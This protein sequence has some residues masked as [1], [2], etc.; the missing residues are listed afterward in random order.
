MENNKICNL[1]F[2]KF[3]RKWNLARHLDDVH[4]IHYDLEK[5][6]MKQ[7]IDVPDNITNIRE[8]KHKIFDED[9]KR[10][11]LQ[12]NQNYYNNNNLPYNF[13]NYYFYNNNNIIINLRYIHF[14]TSIPNIEKKKEN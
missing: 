14:Q 10:S 12:S 3:T 11:Q 7:G 13:P 1:C 6:K 4:K 9:N 5:D 8:T 2:K